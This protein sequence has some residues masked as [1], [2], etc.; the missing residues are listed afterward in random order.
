MSIPGFGSLIFILAA[1]VAV[2]AAVY[3]LRYR[4]IPNALTM[5]ALLSGIVL[6]TVRSGWDGLLFS[7][8]G[9]AIGGGVL[10]AF[11]IVGG[12][13]Q[14]DV[15]LMGGI[16]AL[17]GSRLALSVLIFMGIAGGIMAMGKLAVSYRRRYRIEKKRKLTS[18]R[19]GATVGSAGEG[20]QAGDNP[21]KETMPYGV[22]IAAGT[23]VS[24]VL[25]MVAR[26][27][28]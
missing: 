1:G 25:V 17:V 11:C 28:S 5:P 18:A 19:S 13:G 8:W 24:L 21:M 16:G 9:M 22:A 10:L 23:I 15:K 6:H 3:D 27:A 12:M 2:T 14:G 7:L 4:R 26:G 20:R